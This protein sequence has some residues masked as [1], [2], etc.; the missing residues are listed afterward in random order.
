MQLPFWVREGGEPYSKVGSGGW[1]GLCVGRGG[2]GKEI[3]EWPI[4]S[5][6]PSA[7]GKYLPFDILDRGFMAQGY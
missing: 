6:L 5:Q 1:V 7:L 3:Q 4:T 2:D